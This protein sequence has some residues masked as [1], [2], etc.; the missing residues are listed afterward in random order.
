MI[1]NDLA[2]LKLKKPIVFDNKTTKPIDMFKI[3]E[4]SKLEDKALVPGWGLLQDGDLSMPARVHAVELNIFD[5][6]RCSEFYNFLGGLE[7]GE[8]CTGFD[9]TKFQGICHG[10][11]GG[12]L[13]INNRLAGI[14]TLGHCATS[15]YPDIFTE[16]AHF[17]GWIDR[18]MKLL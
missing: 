5:K 2:I 8:I 12:P 11:S 14:A 6:Q 10:D 16:V 13:I 9:I 7:P 1:A 17:R 15:T 4:E 3:G 18:Q